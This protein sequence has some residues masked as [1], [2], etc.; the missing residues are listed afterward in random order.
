MFALCPGG[1]SSP[2]RFAENF[3]LKRIAEHRVRNTPS[4]QTEGVRSGVRAFH[5]SLPSRV[6]DAVVVRRSCPREYRR[7]G[8]RHDARVSGGDHWSPMHLQRKLPP[9]GDGCV[10]RQQDRR[11]LFGL[12]A[13]PSLSVGRHE[14]RSRDRSCRCAPVF[15]SGDLAARAD[16]IAGRAEGDRS[17]LRYPSDFRYLGTLECQLDGTDVPSA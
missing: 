17:A 14:P 5:Q 1:V 4:E 2:Q 15:G 11:E 9:A 13:A 8:W 12:A 6:R 10:C 16:G 3:G 7:F